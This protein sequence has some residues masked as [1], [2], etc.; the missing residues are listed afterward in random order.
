MQIKE[1]HH[2]L[3]LRRRQIPRPRSARNP[4]RRRFGAA[5]T[6]IRARYRSIWRSGTA[7]ECLEGSMRGASALRMFIRTAEG[8]GVT[9]TRLFRVGG[10]QGLVEAYAAVRAPVDPLVA[11]DDSDQCA[12]QRSRTPRARKPNQLCPKPKH[13]QPKEQ[14]CGGGHEDPWGDHEDLWPV[15]DTSSQNLQQGECA[16]HDQEHVAKAAL[17]VLT[18]RH[19]VRS[20]PLNAAAATLRAAQR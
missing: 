17:D 1:R 10:L 2:R 18:D 16:D 6:R 11:H 5:C 7:R 4:A 8:R 3:D 12:S 20:Y 15:R 9:N 14:R 13:G 19:V